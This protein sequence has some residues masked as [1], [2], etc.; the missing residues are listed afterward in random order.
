MEEREDVDFWGLTQRAES[1]FDGGEVLY[2]THIQLYFYGVKSRMLHSREFKEY[3]ENIMQHV[4]DFRSAIT[5]YEFGFTQYFEQ[6]GFSWDVAVKLPGYD[7]D[8]PHRN[9]SPYHYNCYDL[10]TSG[11]YPFVK[12][13]LFTG[14][15]VYAKY[16]GKSDLRRTFDYIVS[17]TAYDENLIWDYILKNFSLADIMRSLC[18]YEIL[19]EDKS[20]NAAESGER[21]YRIIDTKNEAVP[22]GDCTEKYVLLISM[23]KRSDET[24]ALWNS[25]QFEITENMMCSEEYMKAVM[26]LFE[27]NPRLGV[28]VPPANI[29]GS[30]TDGVMQKWKDNRRATEIY[31]SLKLCVPFSENEAPIHRVNAVWCRKSILESMEQADLLQHIDETVLQM[32]PLIAQNG[33]YY[34]EILENG[35]YV[36]YH[37]NMEREAVRELLEFLEL[38]MSQDMTMEE[39]QTQVMQRKVLLALGQKKELYIYGAG[40]RAYRLIAAIRNRVKIMGIIVSDREG[41]PPHLLG[42]EVR[43]IEELKAGQA[44]TLMV[45]TVGRKHRNAVIHNLEQSGW[46]NYICV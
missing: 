42:C 2:P 38:D 22:I 16:S 14:E 4:T 28:L 46:K 35:N 8:D 6:R 45:I 29:Y 37:L 44:D 12:K 27:Q 20:H 39:C 15:F 43:S 32:I 34:T 19:T 13:K 5:N 1:D 40:E 26:D 18:L 24:E 7:T 31:R 30:I 17:G 11:K 10:V 41:N 21:K 3:W 9:L 25:R 36:K 33:G 23:E